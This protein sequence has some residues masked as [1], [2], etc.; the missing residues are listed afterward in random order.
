MGTNYINNYFHLHGTLKVLFTLFILIYTHNKA[1]R[2]VIV[3]PFYKWGNLCLEK[4]TE[5]QKANRTQ[6][7]MSHSKAAIQ[8]IHHGELLCRRFQLALRNNHQSKMILGFSWLGSGG[9][10][11][12]RILKTQDYLYAYVVNPIWVNSST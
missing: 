4:V 12:T 11:E 2:W 6:N 9:L 8:A 5:D 1:V 10:G 7:W 3:S